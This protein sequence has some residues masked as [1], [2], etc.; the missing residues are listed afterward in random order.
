MD[1]ALEAP[2]TFEHRYGVKFAALAVVD[3]H[4]YV[5]VEKTHPDNL[6][7]AGRLDLPGGAY[8]SFVGIPDES[9]D[10]LYGTEKLW[11]ETGYRVNFPDASPVAIAEVVLQPKN[12]SAPLLNSSHTGNEILLHLNVYE[13]RFRADGQTNSKML[14]LD[15]KDRVEQFPPTNFRYEDPYDKTGNHELLTL[16]ELLELE[17]TQCS[18]AL[19]AYIQYKKKVE[20]SHITY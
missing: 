14:T 16:D 19:W 8:P 1:I 4:E 11:R 12:I 2:K 3:G 7:L 15:P 20:V 10:K 5:L 6:P 18:Q 13:T 17:E 9:R